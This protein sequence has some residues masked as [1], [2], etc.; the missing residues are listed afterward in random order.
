MN[1]KPCFT[2]HRDEL[3]SHSCTISFQAHSRLLT[4]STHSSVSLCVVHLLSPDQPP[5]QCPLGTSNNIPE[6]NSI[7]QPQYPVIPA[8][9]IGLGLGS[10]CGGI[11]GVR[12]LKSNNLNVAKFNI[13]Q[14]V[15]TVNYGNNQQARIQT[16]N[17]IS[18]TALYSTGWYEILTKYQV[19]GS[20]SDYQTSSS[21]YAAYNPKYNN[22]SAMVSNITT[23]AVSATGSG[24]Y[25]A[26]LS[27][28]PS[29]EQNTSALVLTGTGYQ[30]AGG[31]Q[32][33]APAPP[34]VQQTHAPVQYT[35]APATTLAPGKPYGSIGGK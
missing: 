29:Q 10:P 16:T 22:P 17:R 8:D 31:A 34:P 7:S 18:S 3:F 28:T 24:Y 25:A 30:I 15:V 4:R 21:I 1:A 9:Q 33:L 35:Q 12:Y 20:G 23:P 11:A 19:V 5:C 13:S 26:N 32:T 14:G 6:F 2:E 27:F